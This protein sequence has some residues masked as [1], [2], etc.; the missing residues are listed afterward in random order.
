VSVLV[1]VAGPVGAADL[2]LDNTCPVGHLLPELCAAL[3]VPAAAL[4]TAAGA[5]LDAARTLA[6][7]GVLDGDRLTLVPEAAAAAVPAGAYGGSPAPPVLACYLAL[8]TSDSM[9]GPALDA[10]GAELARLWDAVGADARLA[11]AC[12]LAVV[13]FDAEARIHVPLTP[14]TGW[15]RPPRLAATRP[16]TN[17]EAA[18]RLLR[19]VVGDD[20]AALRADGLR[21]VRPAVFL[22]TDGRPTRGAWPPA[23]AALTD[24]AWRDA[25]DVVAFGFGDAAGAAVRRIGTAGAYLPSAAPGGRV[26]APAGML[27]TFMSFLLAALGGSLAGPRERIAL[28]SQVPGGWRR[29]ASGSC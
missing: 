14:V 28:P 5:P 24:P 22:L 15:E 16:A 1:T 12:R 29:L 27:A 4:H 17:Y 10:A 21:P 3:G 25:P 9:A 2:E 20:L 13:T 11:A 8:D 19:R 7:G 26:A 18:F 23:H 6:A